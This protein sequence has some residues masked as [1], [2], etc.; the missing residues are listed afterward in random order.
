MGSLRLLALIVGALLVGACGKSADT[1]QATS[2]ATAFGLHAA[3]LERLE[4]AARAGDC[5]AALRVGRHFSLGRNDSINA[6]P[7]LRRAANCGAPQVKAELAY[8]LIGSF[9]VSQVDAE[10]EALATEIEKADAGLA[11]AVRD[12][13]IGLRLRTGARE[14]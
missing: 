5:E 12:E 6:V 10:V 14:K 1:V 13:L 4:A 9:E 2:G 7:W 11:R 8:I 3:E